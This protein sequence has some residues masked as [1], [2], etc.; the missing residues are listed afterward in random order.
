MKWNDRLRCYTLRQLNGTPPQWRRYSGTMPDFFL[1]FPSGHSFVYL[2]AVFSDSVPWRLSYSTHMSWKTIIL[3]FIFCLYLMERIS[4]KGERKR[5][6]WVRRQIQRQCCLMCI[7][8][9]HWTKLSPFPRISY[10]HKTSGVSSM[11]CLRWDLYITL[12]KSPA[13][14]RT[15]H[16]GSHWVPPPA[17]SEII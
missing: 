15:T 4:Q 2:Y 1:L 17:R 6:K 13:L 12:A 16:R 14:A 3:E 8:C 11:G 7:I 9:V 10:F 5:R